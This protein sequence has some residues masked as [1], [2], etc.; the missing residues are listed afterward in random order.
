MGQKE[1]FQ[2]RKTGDIV[3]I[4]VEVLED[5]QDGIMQVR[6]TD[7]ATEWVFRATTSKGVDYLEPLPF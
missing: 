4:E 5:C 1:N 2:D 7:G 6:H 3:S